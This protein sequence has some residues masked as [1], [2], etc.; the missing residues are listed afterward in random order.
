MRYRGAPSARRRDTFN[1]LTS[2][3]D[4]ARQH[5]NSNMTIMLIGNKCDLE[6]RRAVTF[7]EGQTFAN[8]NGLVFL[9]TSAKT[10][11][12]VEEA[13]INTAR[14]IYEKIQQVTTPRPQLCPPPNSPAVPSPRCATTRS[15][16]RRP[17][18]VPPPRLGQTTA[19]HRRRPP[20]L[21]VAAR[22]PHCRGSSTCRTSRT[23]S[24]SGWQRRIRVG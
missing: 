13:F 11:A 6:Q 4:D 17:V 15:R 7:E 19:R 22:W 10:A 14:K 9:E 8:E 16:C 24:R 12:N 23:A 18:V 5:A 1:H 2:W 21:T 20:L 3:L